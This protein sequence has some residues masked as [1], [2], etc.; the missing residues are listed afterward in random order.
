MTTHTGVHIQRFKHRY[1]TNSFP[2]RY[3]TSGLTLK[4]TMKGLNSSNGLTK[5]LNE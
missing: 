2:E 4:T 1:V 5:P 3:K